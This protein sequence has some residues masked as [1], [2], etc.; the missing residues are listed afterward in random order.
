LTLTLA[1]LNKKVNPKGTGDVMM[2]AAIRDIDD[3]V[4]SLY[5]RFAQEIYNYYY[6]SR[7]CA[8]GNVLYEIASGVAP[9]PQQQGSTPSTSSQAVPQ[10][11]P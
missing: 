6:K 5:N 10:Q 8:K 2:M 4:K 11:T 9:T 1:C 7:G 3:E